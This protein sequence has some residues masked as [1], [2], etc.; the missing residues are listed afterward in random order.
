MVEFKSC[1]KNFNYN[2]KINKFKFCVV[3]D[4]MNLKNTVQTKAGLS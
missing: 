3:F 1:S 4:R 2:E